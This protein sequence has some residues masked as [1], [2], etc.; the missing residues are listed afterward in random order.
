MIQS[1][2]KTTVQPTNLKIAT[3]DVK[4]M[5]C[6]GCVSAVERQLTQNTGVTSACV[7]LVTEV[8][9]VEYS[10]EIVQPENL[11]QKLTDIGFPTQPR[12][13]ATIEQ[14]SQKANQKRETEQKEQIRGLIVAGMLL[15]FSTLGHLEHSGGRA[16]LS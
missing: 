11:A 14:V 7:N 13:W 2:E 9:V 16:F 10:P 15:F 6:A 8:A 4:G 5:K 3:F 12:A 1:P